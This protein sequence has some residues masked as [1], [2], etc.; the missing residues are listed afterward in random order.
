[1]Q[2]NCPI[3]IYGILF[4]MDPIST[5]LDYYPALVIDGALATELERRGCDLKD[6]LWS[7]RV[8]LEQPEVIRQV[9]LDYFKAGADCAIT[10]SYQATVEGFQRR[11][12]NEKE[13]IDLI[14]T[15]V[16]LAL[17]AR[18]EFWSETTNRTGRARPFVAASVGPYGAFLA[19][20][21]EYR[22]DY[23]MSEKD[24]MDFHRPRMRAL[25][26]A[27]ADM[28]ACETIPSLIE[29]RAIAALLREFPS[30]SAWLS[31]SARDEKHISE[32]QLLVDCVKE[33]ESHTQ[34][35]AIGVN[36]TSPK[37]IPGLIGN[38]KQA[39]EKPV[40]VYP[41]SGE[42]YDAE[43]NAWN[44]DRVLSSFGEHAREWYRAGARLI[45][46]CCRTT[47]ED[48]QVIASWARN[49]LLMER[50]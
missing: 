38:T 5:I 42:S 31:F 24:L 21:S 14:Q 50:T 48:I 44:G 49:D 8:L 34:I 22:G 10:A 12:L 19:D 16:H 6:D 33:L 36:C 47:P 1:M 37:Y 4:L 30:I 7:A 9:H 13:S 32:G 35:A 43:K 26:E 23:A 18:D 3:F 46:G 45:G 39:T 40:L 2:K 28:L 20:G 15:S 25:V 27:G 41:N 11:G 29:A 17:A